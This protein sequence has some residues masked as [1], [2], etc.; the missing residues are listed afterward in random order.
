MSV[1]E[2]DRISDTEVEATVT[3]F[4][5]DGSQESERRYFRFVEEDGILKIDESSN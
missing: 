4:Y 1:S 2:V 5:D 3:Y